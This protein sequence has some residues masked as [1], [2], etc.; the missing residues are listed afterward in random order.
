[1]HEGESA[2]RLVTR[3]AEALRTDYES[4]RQGAATNKCRRNLRRRIGAV[5]LH[6]SL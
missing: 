4:A 5:R 3:L 1:V 2:V 6:Q